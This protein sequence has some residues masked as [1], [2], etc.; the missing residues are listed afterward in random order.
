MG[1]IN[2]QDLQLKQ[3]FEDTLGLTINR[4]GFNR[5][6]L[7]YYMYSR[8]HKQQVLFEQKPDTS[9]SCTIAGVTRNIPGR[10]ALATALGHTPTALEICRIVQ[11]VILKMFDDQR[12]ETSRQVGRDFDTFS[13]RGPK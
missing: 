11:E 7:T 1:E 4:A 2:K 13:R 9:M 6:T 3:F 10:E 5:G 12:D 8:Q